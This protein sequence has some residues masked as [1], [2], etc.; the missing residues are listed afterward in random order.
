M[1]QIVLMEH[2]QF[3][4]PQMETAR[5]AIRSTL[6][7]SFRTLLEALPTYNLTTV[8]GMNFEEFEK[9]GTTLDA[10]LVKVIKNLWTDPGIQACASH[11]A[12]LGLMDTTKL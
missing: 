5:D 2:Q 10:A 12:E 9:M 8:S 3:D 1:K 11:W 4:E 6:L 7:L